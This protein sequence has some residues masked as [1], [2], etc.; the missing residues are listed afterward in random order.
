MIRSLSQ[1]ITS[2]LYRQ[3]AE[4]LS[5]TGFQ[6]DIELSYADRTVLSTDNSIYQVLPE[7]VV[8]PTSTE[9]LSALL[10]LAHQPEFHSIVLSPRGGGTGTNGQ[11][12]TSGFM[13]DT[14]RYMNR[15][16]EIN[17]QELSLIH[18]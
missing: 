4:Q 12:L 18:I 2:H 6:G 7:G 17:A 11:S 15:V 16:L 5:D 8:Y 3:F 9:D 14:S 13:V 10:S 1:T